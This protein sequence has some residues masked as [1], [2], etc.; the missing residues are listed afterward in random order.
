MPVPAA[1]LIYHPRRERRAF[2]SATVY[3]DGTAGNQDPYVW[4]DAFLHSYCHITQFHAEAE[5]INL[6]VSGDR[7]PQFSQLYCDLVFVVARKCA[8]DDANDLRR[9]DPLVDSEEAWADH[10]RWYPQHPLTRRSR[11]TLKADPGCSFQSQTEDGNLIDI[12][13][14]LQEHGIGLPELWAGMHA[15]IGS[16]PM[17]IAI[18][19][20]E[21]VA[22]TLKHAPVILTGPELRKVRL[23]HPD[24]ASPAPAGDVPMNQI[25]EQ[26]RHCTHCG[27]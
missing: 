3:F 13:P 22:E 18:A 14:L 19:G 24:L 23:D 25:T 5:D 11:Y 15:G 17:T 12:V 2:D 16:Q 6:W 1:R 27:C 7:F 20:A 8:W 10:Y 21:A 4:N 9:D 26:S